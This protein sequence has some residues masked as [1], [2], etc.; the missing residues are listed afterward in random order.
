MQLP[1]QQVGVYTYYSDQFEPQCPLCQSGEHSSQTESNFVQQTHAMA[2]QQVRGRVV[3]T[4]PERIV[5]QKVIEGVALSPMQLRQ[6]QAITPPRVMPIAPQ[7]INTPP[8]I[9]QK[10][11]ILVQQSP[12]IFQQA[13]VQQ[14]QSP[15]AI[16]SQ[17]N[18]IQQA[19]YQQ[20]IPPIQQQYQFQP[21]IQQAQINQTNISAQLNQQL[22]QSQLV[23]QELL[24]KQ[25]EWAEKY[26]KQT[27][28][29]QQHNLAYS[30][31]QAQYQEQME[32]YEA[33]KQAYSLQ[34]QYSAQNFIP[35]FLQ[36]VQYK[37]VNKDGKSQYSQ[38]E[39]ELYWR[40]QV[41][42]LEQKMYQLW[43]KI[44]EKKQRKDLPTKSE[45]T[46]KIEQLQLEVGHL[47]H[48]QRMKMNSVVILRNKLNDLMY[49][50]DPATEATREYDLQLQQ[51]R[52]KVMQLN[53]RITDIQDE[54]QMAEAQ[55]EAI[56]S[57][58]GFKFVSV[59]QTTSQVRQV[60]NSVRS[61]Q[62]QDYQVS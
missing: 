61:N 34:T 33:L 12:V 30:Q 35:S 5:S 29:M 38:E 32:Q 39:I 7:V 6:Q 28:E 52:Q 27:E 4:T 26:Y 60:T 23:Q 36:T 50:H 16:N 42:Q 43:E 9:Q 40:H 19:I 46:Q 49:Q 8:I 14:Q 11:P 31:L 51:L 44:N 1:S 25:K 21:Q 48:I 22:Q 2:G 57:G 56:R 59:K 13:P 3:Y 53:S 54:T 18:V 15:I 24:L 55:N 20:Q 10:S 41:F 17:S 47:E 58:K 37:V 45:D 62:V